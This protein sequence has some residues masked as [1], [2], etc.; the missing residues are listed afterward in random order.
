MQR[1]T[2]IREAFSEGILGASMRAQA[3]ATHR[4]LLLVGGTLGGLLFAAAP[5]LARGSCGSAGASALLNIVSF[6][7]EALVGIGGVTFLLMIAVGGCLI[8]F[9]GTGRRVYKGQEIIKQSLI[10]LGVIA[11]G[12]VVKYVIVDIVFSQHPGES[13][14]PT[15]CR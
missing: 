8:I 10:G 11:I 4:R 15:T 5:A 12:L 14:L 2:L 3:L 1:L 7:A 13:K 9:G 6:I